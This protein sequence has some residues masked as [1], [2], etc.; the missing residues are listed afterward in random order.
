[1]LYNCLRLEW[2]MTMIYSLSAS[3][4]RQNILIRSWSSEPSSE[5][6]GCDCVGGSMVTLFIPLPPKA[7][8]VRS[9]RLLGVSPRMS[10]LVSLCI[11]KALRSPYHNK[12]LSYH[13]DNMQCGCKSPQPM[14]I[15]FCPVYNLCSLNSPTHYTVSQKN[16]A[17]LLSS[18]LR[19]ISTNFDNFWQKDGKEAK[20]MRSALIFHLV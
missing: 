11:W 8:S 12:K 7:F 20:L 16:C 13:R 2:F 18:E 15:I 10:Q 5:I 4:L 14:S 9:I 17:K 6:I 19:Q 1:M 3:Y